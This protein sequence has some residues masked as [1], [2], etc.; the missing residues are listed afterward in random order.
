[1]EFVVRERG[2]ASIRG[3]QMQ[4]D[5]FVDEH[6]VEVRERVGVAGADLAAR[7]AVDDDAGEQVHHRGEPVVDVRGVPG[8]HRT[9]D[10]VATAELSED[11]HELRP[12]G[13]ERF[14]GVDDLVEL[15]EGSHVGGDRLAH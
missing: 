14:G 10:R 7:L 1:M 13:V 5:V 9:G 12:C 11:R 6:R 2:G 15:L 4:E 8:E 3:V